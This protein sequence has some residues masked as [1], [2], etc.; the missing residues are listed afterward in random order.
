[1]HP[2][3]PLAPEPDLLTAVP[4]EDVALPADGTEKK[5]WHFVFEVLPLAAFFLAYRQFGIWTATEI[6][7][8]VTAFCVAAQW[9]LTRRLPVLTLLSGII[10]GLFGMLTLWL[11]DPQFI[12]MK[13]TL[14]Y[15]LFALILAGGR[16]LGHNPLAKVFGQVFPLTPN[17][18]RILTWRWVA[19]FLAL[20][21]GNEILWRHVSEAV[22][23][24]YKVFGFLPLTLLF[25][26]CQMRLLM[27]ESIRPPS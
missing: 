19:L 26:A 22:W 2:Q 25:G 10:V 1:M 20:A 9:F 21:I 24:N 3:E 12:K 23:V 11:H 17:G 14:I 4:A 15:S 13:P 8:G 27:R 5:S 16:L 18:W 6:L 7:M